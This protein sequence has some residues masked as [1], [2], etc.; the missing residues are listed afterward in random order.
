MKYPS[1]KAA[2]FQV[3]QLLEAKTMAIV[4][5]NCVNKFQ[6]KQQAFDNP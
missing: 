2:R 6:A 1:E 3:G 4:C 5:N